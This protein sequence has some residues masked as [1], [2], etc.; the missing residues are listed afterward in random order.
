MQRILVLILPLT[1]ASMA[2]AATY[3]LTADSTSVC[4]NVTGSARDND[5]V[6]IMQRPDFCGFIG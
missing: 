1:V 4:P 2:G 6:M 5:A 3:D